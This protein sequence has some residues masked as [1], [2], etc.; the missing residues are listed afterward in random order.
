[1][2]KKQK[3]NPQKGR[4]S[5][6]V[7][8]EKNALILLLILLFITFTDAILAITIPNNPAYIYFDKFATIFAAPFVL[9]TLGIVFSEINKMNNDNK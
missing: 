7:Y 4:R 5:Y 1:M 8:S 3:Q 2:S 6:K 9:F